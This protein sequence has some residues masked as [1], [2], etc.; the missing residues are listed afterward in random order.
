MSLY[1]QVGTAGPVWIERHSFDFRVCFC[2][3]NLSLAAER[4]RLCHSCFSADILVHSWC[5]LSAA[6]NVATHTHTLR[7]TW[8]TVSDSRNLI[9]HV[10]IPGRPLWNNIGGFL[11][12]LYSAASSS[13]LITHFFFFAQQ[14][15]KTPLF[16]CG[17]C[18]HRRTTNRQSF[19]PPLLSVLP[20]P[21]VIMQVMKSSCPWSEGDWFKLVCLI[22][23]LPKV[24]ILTVTLTCWLAN[25][26]S[27]AL[28]HAGISPL[29]LFNF[30]TLL[31]PSMCVCVC[32]QSVC[33]SCGASSD[34]LPFTEL[35]HYI[36]TTALW[37]GTGSIQTFSHPSCSA[38]GTQCAS[39]PS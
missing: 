14:T 32:L 38:L 4:C 10:F 3:P 33:R 12:Q 6:T 5:S 19:A 36:S 26:S 39:P 37:W 2:L 22:V 8:I 16:P 7:G 18:A 34:P 24:L 1:E 29:C 31:S 15:L 17:S 23:S 25:C 20:D 21:A 35:V 28:L 11:V 30:I 9:R 13:R 27:T